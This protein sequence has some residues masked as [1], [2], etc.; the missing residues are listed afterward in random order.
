[1]RAEKGYSFIIQIW[2][3]YLP[4]VLETLPCIDL[5]FDHYVSQQS[6]ESWIMLT[7]ERLNIKSDSECEKQQEADLCW[8]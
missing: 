7:Q 1:M 4:V 8:C 5:Y 2:L 3:D 6:V